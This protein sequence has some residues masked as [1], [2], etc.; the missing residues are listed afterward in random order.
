VR[1]SERQEAYQSV[2]ILGLVLTSRLETPGMDLML[3]EAVPQE[4]Q[5]WE[6][7]VLD[8]AMRLYSLAVR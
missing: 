7:G 3:G 5:M 1:E 4:P 2:A 6:L 8:F